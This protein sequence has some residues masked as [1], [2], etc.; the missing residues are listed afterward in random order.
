M[1]TW[2]DD[3]IFYHIYPLG[4]L[5]A[6]Q[7]NDHGAEPVSRLADLAVWGE[8]IRTLGCNAVY[9]GPV[10]ESSTHGYDTVDYHMVDRRLGTN[11]DLRTLI[12]GWH[13]LGLKV[14]LDG[15]FNHVSRDF[16]AFRDLV[17]HGAS[18]V[19]RDWFAGVD[20][21]VRSP[22]GD[23][24][25]YDAWAGNYE[26]VKLNLDNPEVREYHFSSIRMWFRTFDIDGIR[27]DTADVIDLGFLHDLAAVAREAQPD[28][29]LMG[30]VVH[31]DYR[32]WT[33]PGMLDSCT[34]YECFK[35]LYS[36]F[37]DRNMHEIA[38]SLNRQFGPD[39]IYR[40]LKL[41]SFADNHDVN[42][43]ASL[44]DRQEDL[45][46]LYALLFTIPGVPSIYYGSEWGITGEKHDGNDRALR[47][48]LT[49]PPSPEMNLQP[50]L[51]T[52]IAL[53]AEI[54]V[55]S[56]ALINGDYSQVHVASEQFAFVRRADNDVA[57]VIVNASEGEVALELVGDLPNGTVLIDR[58]DP[59]VCATVQRGLLPIPLPPGSARILTGRTA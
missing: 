15:V 41:Y 1:T 4:L 48:A 11:D 12:E 26:L 3:A 17:T 57:L 14:I 54:R 10:F 59:T 29:W 38:W 51:V 40:N 53:L 32:A 56:P 28:C 8:H 20:F 35:G 44:L 36:S 25:T 21:S 50:W 52:F 7:E 31:E 16:P 39:G 23:A 18:S 55:G 46:S 45:A 42:R 9:L 13:D 58:L 2:I 34:N 19:Y 37:N 43:V 6:P 22:R 5:G 49:L 24:F 47:P 27:I 30:E 33:A